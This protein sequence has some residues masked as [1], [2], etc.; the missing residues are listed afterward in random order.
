MVSVRMDR[1]MHPIIGLQSENVNGEGRGAAVEFGVD[2]AQIRA[3][4]L[5]YRV[6]FDPRTLGEGR[7]GNRPLIAGHRP[8]PQRKA[9]KWVDFKLEFWKMC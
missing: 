3:Y 8:L 6:A 5:C 7:G 2:K 9:K 1:I 4:Y